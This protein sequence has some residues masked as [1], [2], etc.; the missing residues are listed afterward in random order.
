MVLQL[1]AQMESLSSFDPSIVA[2]LGVVVT[3]LAGALVLMAKTLAETK[4]VNAAVNNRPES[5]GLFAQISTLQVGVD[6]LLV[7]EEDF[8]K[9]GW[10]SLPEDLDSGAK[11]TQAIRDLQSFDKQ[12]E[13]ALLD[14]RGF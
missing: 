12:V 7:A 5:E 6:R 11:L 8:A 1:I 13:E 14:L 10:R 4:Q 3:M 2:A 9:K